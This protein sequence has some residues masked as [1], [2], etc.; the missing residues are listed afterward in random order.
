MIKVSKIR[1][2][3]NPALQTI[4]FL[5]SVWFIYHFVFIKTEVQIL[6]KGL[7]SGMSGELPTL[8]TLQLVSTI[9]LMGLNW[10]I[11]ARK[12]QLLV[13]PL[14]YITLFRAVRAVLTGISLSFYTPNR[15]G[16]YPARS[17]ILQKTSITEGIM[18]TM[19]GSLAQMLITIMAGSFSLILVIKNFNLS[20]YNQ[21]VSFFILSG[22]LTLLVFLLLTFY[23]NLP[24]ICRKLPINTPQFL[25]RLLNRLTI[26]SVYRHKELLVILL[27]SAIRYLVFTTQYYLLLRFFG[28]TLTFFHAFELIAVVYFITT[29][30]PSIALTELGIRGS[31][32]IWVFAL[33]QPFTGMIPEVFNAAVL[34]ASVSLWLINIG[35]PAIIGS[36]LIFRLKLSKR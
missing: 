12:W 11:E 8:K 32:A 23:M 13:K 34:S 35:A 15:V 31:V 3:L 22:L 7:I 27:L 16:E 10:I 17:M 29:L 28:L 2:F 20:I 5:L 14:E 25:S 24:H 26:F 33:Y 21:N 19:A 18:V 36:L 9:L 6:Y 1:K 4:L 30:I